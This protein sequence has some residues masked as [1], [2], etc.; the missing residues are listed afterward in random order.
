MGDKV[1]SF[2]D[3]TLLFGEDG[4]KSDL[5]ITSVDIHLKDYCS[6]VEKQI[7]YHYNE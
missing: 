6:G 2:R 3:F 4:I 1:Y 7:Y 5:Q